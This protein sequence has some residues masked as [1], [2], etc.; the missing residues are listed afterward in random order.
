MRIKKALSLLTAGLLT[1]TLLTACDS[2][3]STETTTSS[4]DGDSEAYE[5]LTPQQVYETLLQAEDFVFLTVMDRQVTGATINMTYMLEK[6][7]DTLRYTVY[8]DAED[9]TYDVNSVIYIDLGKNIC[10]APSG[11]EWYVLEDSESFSVAALIENC[12]PADLLF[13]SQNYTVSDGNYTLSRD[14]IL[15]MIGSTTA[16]VSGAMRSE[17]D[18]YTFEV[19]TEEATNVITMTTKVIFR[20][21]GIEMPTYDLNASGQ[22]GSAEPDTD[23]EPS[24]TADGSESVEEGGAE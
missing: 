21:V 11:D 6:D 4:Q 14:A 9:D 7:G 1:L 13:D 18:T 3:G 23:E 5:N 2:D 15:N 22:S 12:T 19:I 24:E 10:I 8:Q 17:G 20:N 16:T